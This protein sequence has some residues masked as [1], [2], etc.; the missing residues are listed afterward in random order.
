MSDSKNS[1]LS[2]STLILLIIKA[3]VDAVVD[4]NIALENASFRIIIRLLLPTLHFTCYVLGRGEVHLCA[5]YLLCVIV[6][7]WWRG[8]RFIYVYVFMCNVL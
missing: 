7:C 1:S 6:M 3:W 2:P 5:Y 8:V 4:S